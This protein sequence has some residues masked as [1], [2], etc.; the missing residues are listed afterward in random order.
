MFVVVVTSVGLLLRNVER[1][2]VVSLSVVGVVG[3]AAAFGAAGIGVYPSACAAGGA[4]GRRPA[5]LQLSLIRLGGTLSRSRSDLIS[6]IAR[7][8]SVECYALLCNL[9]CAISVV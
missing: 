3:S 4:F 7:V 8:T 1:V 5:C 6:C 9:C 2:V